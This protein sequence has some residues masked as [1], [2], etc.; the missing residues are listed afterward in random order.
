[1]SAKS[2]TKHLST[3][4]SK[5]ITVIIVVLAVG[6]FGYLAL[7]L[8][9][10]ATP[11]ASFEAE[12]GTIS[13][14]ATKPSD[15]TASGGASVKFQAGTPP[16]G[17]TVTIA[18]AGDIGVSPGTNDTKTANL[19]KADTSISAVLVAGD[20]AYPN[21]TAAEFEYYDETWGQ[22]KNKSYPAIGNHELFSTKQNYIDYWQNNG[23]WAT[24]SQVAPALVSA[25]TSSKMYYS[26][27]IGSWHIIA[28]DSADAPR[29]SSSAQVTWLKADLAAN[30][31]ACTLAFFHHPWVSDAGTGAAADITPIVQAL[32]ADK[33]DVVIAGHEH[34]YV[35]FNK[36]DATGKASATGIR[37]WVVGAGGTG[38]GGNSAATPHPQKALTLK[39]N[40]Y[41]K[42]VLSPTSYT[43][44]YINASGAV[45]DT[46]SDTCTI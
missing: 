14:T 41:M 11:A 28:L 5:L 39:E 8:S 17:Q 19:I 23:K 25:M 26:L 46:G 40:G 36:M 27:N 7:R 1:M 12:S 18:A 10:A 15:A 29:T 22:F 3:K 37:H 24:T 6:G 33:A 21:G 20:L 13:G 30:T 38:A 2:L 35:K 32:A 9:G 4:P 42:M 34:K 45:R 43:W 31:S 16:T 44:Q